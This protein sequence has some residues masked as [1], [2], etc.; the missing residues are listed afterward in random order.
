MAHWEYCLGDSSRAKLALVRVPTLRLSAAFLFLAGCLYWSQAD[1]RAAEAALQS[2]TNLPPLTNAQ[3]VLDLG[4]EAARHTVFSA[5]LQGSVTYPDPSANRLFLQDSSAGILVVYTNVSFQPSPGQIIVV[6]G[7]VAGGRF[8]PYIDCSHVRLIGFSAAPDPCE[9]QAARLAAG[10]L[11]GQWVQVEGVVRDI[12][13]DPEGA[14]LFISS[15]GLR[16]NAVIQ[17][18]P[19]LA[20]PVEWLDA[21]VVLRGVCCTDGDV[22]NKPTGFTLYV[23]GT[24]QIS[25]V[26]PGVRDIFLQPTLSMTSQTELRRQSD[27]R[28]KVKGVVTFQSLSGYVYLQGEGGV[29]RA[30]LFAP[31]PR[32][33]PQARYVDRPLVKPLRPGERVELVGAPTNEIFAPLLQDAEIRILGEGPPPVAQSVSV[34]EIFTGKYEGQLIS[35]KATVLVSETRPVGTYKQQVLSLKSGDTIFEALWEFSGTNSLPAPA[36]KSYVEA[37]GICAVQLGEL[38]LVRSFRLLMREPADLRLLGRPQWWESFPVGRMFGAAGVLVALALGWIWLLRRQVSQRTLELQAEIAERQRAQTGLHHALAAERELGELRTRFVSMVSHEF[39]TPLGVIMSAAE[40][41]DNYF[42]RLK[43]EQRRAQ[44]QSV[45]QAAGQMAKVMENVLLLGRAEAGKME[46]KPVPL[47]L[48]SFCEGLAHQVHSSA[49]SRSRIE[50]HAGILPPARGDE[51][52]LRHILSNL[53]ANAIK[54]SKEG[55]PVEFT[56]ERQQNDAIF[57]VRDRGIGIP[58]ADQ[59][60]LFN[61]FYRGSNASHLPGTGL[62]L[63]IVKRCVELHGGQINCESIEGEGTKFTLRLPLFQDN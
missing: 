36:P 15:G 37:K 44:L 55:A 59:K 4:L 51:G 49:E 17:P 31:L 19:G 25:F 5:R 21:R 62:G 1:L 30:R 53:L 38:N 9:A 2:I 46:F 41:L 45:T 33:N 3:S 10:E 12:A 39:R 18:F 43:P 13:K 56:I 20:L 14:I 7:T 42:D 48:V 11:F 54:Y 8:A 47:D 40:N 28:V 34:G 35:V 26:R 60:Q 57:R 58:L 23:A 52:L 27:T 6:D 50:F 22:E 24:N 61:A 29:V 16:F 63:V 32:G